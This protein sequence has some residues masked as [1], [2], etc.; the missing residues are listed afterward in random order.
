MFIALCVLF[1]WVAFLSFLYIY[2]YVSQCAIHMYI[3]AVC[4]TEFILKLYYD[5]NYVLGIMLISLLYF[6]REKLC[7]LMMSL[8]S[9]QLCLT[10]VIAAVQVYT[11]IV[12]IT[13]LK[14]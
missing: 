12:R 14:N 1:V 13:H 6:E 9:D 3:I 2:F 11:V 7:L 8:P 5:D 10:P 4:G